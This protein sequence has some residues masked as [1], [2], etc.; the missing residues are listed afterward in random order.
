MVCAAIP[1]AGRSHSLHRRESPGAAAAAAKVLVVPATAAPAG[2]AAA[3]PLETAE[4]GD[5]DAVEPPIPRPLPHPRRLVQASGGG[6]DWGGPR[7]P[8][9]WR[10]CCSR[11]DA[12]TGQ[13]R[14]GSTALPTRAGAA[15]LL[16][17]RLRRRRPPMRRSFQRTVKV[18]GGGGGR[19]RLCRSCP[20][21]IPVSSEDGEDGG[22]DD[23]K[24]D[25]DDVGEAAPPMAARAVTAAAAAVAVAGV[26]LCDALRI[27]RQPQVARSFRLLCAFPAPP[28]AFH[29]A[30][31]ATAACG[32]RLVVYIHEGVALLLVRFLMDPSSAGEVFGAHREV[33]TERAARA[34]ARTLASGA[35]ATTATTR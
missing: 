35:A 33:T 21:D 18:G 12:Q 31:C 26:P 16:R 30:T 17:R 22:H 13:R 20:H 34:R 8:R 14:G 23:G 11:L 28:S 2:A 5:G 3:V 9:C 7:A 10:L 4:A 6:G 15:A 25:G 29:G 1:C 32:G 19:C 27:P 24:N